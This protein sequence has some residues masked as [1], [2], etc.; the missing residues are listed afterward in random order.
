MSLSKLVLPFL[1]LISISDGQI[2]GVPYFENFDGV[3]SPSLPAGWSTT[4]NRSVTGDFV[5]TRSTPLSDSNAVVSTNATIQQALLSPPLDFTALVAESLIFHE[6]RSST[7]NSG[8]IIEASLDG[9]ST[10][11]FQLSDTLHNTGSTIYIRRSL[12]LSSFVDGQP[13]VTIR[14]RVLGNGSGV[15]GTI[16]FDDIS[17]TARGRIDAAITRIA[18]L[19][20]FPSA[21]DTLTIVATMKNAGTEVLEQIPVN[22]FEDQNSDS[23]PQA[24]EL[25]EQTIVDSQVDPGD[26]VI[27]QIILLGVRFGIHTIIAQAAMPRDVNRNNDQMSEFVSIGLSR[28]SIVINEIM[29]APPSGEPEWVE[30]YNTTSG[31]ID[32][33][34]WRLGNRTLTSRY[35][36]AGSPAPLLPSEYVV[37]T[38]DTALFRSVHQ[39]LSINIVQSA[40]LPTFLFNNSGDAV[41]ILDARGMMMDSTH[42]TPSWGGQHGS[43]LERIEASPNSTDSSNWASSGDSSRSTPGR[44]NFLT[45]LEYNLRLVNIS[46]D[47]ALTSGMLRIAVLVQNVGKSSTGVYAVSLFSDGNRD[48]IPQASELIETQIL[49]SPLAYKDSEEVIFDWSPPTFGRTYLIAEVNDPRDQRISDN[50]AF[51]IATIG[52]T[53]RAVIINEIMY[54]PMSGEAEYVELMNRS[55]SPIDLFDWKLSDIVDTSSA[56]NVHSFAR[57]SMN[58][59]AGMYVTIA[60]DSSILK[61]FPYLADSAFHLIIKKSGFSLNN[62]GDQ[63]IL[64]DVARQTMD[65]V[66]Y[67][68]TWQNSLL[69]D[70]HGRSLERINPEFPSNDRRNWSTSADPRGGTPGRKNS[71]FT[72]P[73]LANSSLSCSPNPFSPDADGVE[74]VTIISYNAPSTTGLIR[75]RIYDSVGRLVRTLAEHEPTGAHGEI[76]W[77][78]LND[79]GERV[80]MGI[81]VVLLEVLD[82]GNGAMY[83]LKGAVVVA[84]KL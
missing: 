37:V 63:V 32:L 71:L 33:R 2:R 57:T 3:I 77:N 59:G 54:D 43:S 65:S 64:Y 75:V 52:F 41:V 8:L 36:I 53:A 23:L 15:S 11:P 44:Q 79:R 84:S 6:R 7:H 66:S 40:S 55:A 78:G 50:T 72:I 10:F 22:F 21:G 76:I 38:K 70:P 58:I 67:L 20:V 61:S 82:G 17:F 80:R 42:Y 45:P 81:Y 16:R 49:I 30:L 73:G 5:T 60:T 14:W 68:P 74:D 83:T 35:V 62:G 28:R 26:S 12:K 48:S 47:D 18:I 46:V 31:T 4:T 9:G 34:S 13:H 1:L 69:D 19:P 56:P 27:S 29:Y 39:D 24:N 51:G 25:L